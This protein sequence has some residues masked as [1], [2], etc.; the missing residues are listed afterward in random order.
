LERFSSSACSS[1]LTR[2]PSTLFDD[3]FAHR[4]DLGAEIEDLAR[5]LLRPQRFGE[6]ARGDAA[7]LAA[8]PRQRSRDDPPQDEAGRQHAAENQRAGE[9]QQRLQRVGGARQVRP[10]ARRLGVERA[11][12]ARERAAHDVEQPLAVNVE[13]ERLALGDVRPD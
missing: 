4:V 8:E 1:S 12:E 5:S 2:A 9:D 3:P 6:L 11:H 13:R 7:R 10:R